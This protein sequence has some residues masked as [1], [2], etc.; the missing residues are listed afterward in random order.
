[1]WLQ[2]RGRLEAGVTELQ[3]DLRE[4]NDPE[5]AQVR[6]RQAGRQSGSAARPTVVCPVCSVQ[7][8]C[9]RGHGQ[10]CAPGQSGDIC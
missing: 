5:D 9:V 2:A 4:E 3:G 6:G 7:R 8:G 1:M 10:G